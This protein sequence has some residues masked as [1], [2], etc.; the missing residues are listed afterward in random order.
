[1]ME[2]DCSTDI[3]SMT[4]TLVD[5]CLQRVTEISYSQDDLS[6][7][8][9]IMNKLVASEPLLTKIHLKSQKRCLTDRKVAPGSDSVVCSILN[10]RYC[11]CL[12]NTNMGKQYEL[13]SDTYDLAITCYQ[14]ALIWYP[15]S[16]EAGHL[17]GLCLRSRA[18]TAEKLDFVQ[19]IWERAM[20]AA[21]QTLET[22]G[23]PGTRT[24]GGTALGTAPSSPFTLPQQKVWD[25]LLSSSSPFP[26]SEL[27]SALSKSFVDNSTIA[28]C[29][30]RAQ[31]AL[32]FREREAAK[33]LQDSLILFY[34][35]ENQLDNAYPLLLLKRYQ[36]KLSQQVLTHATEEGQ[37]KEAKE[38]E[39]RQ[40]QLLEPRADFPF[41][42]GYDSVLPEI[43]LQRLQHVFRPSA[44][45]WSEHQYDFYSNCSRKV[46]Y[47][48]YLYPFRDRSA[49]NVIEQVIDI[50]Y[51][52]VTAQLEASNSDSSIS[53]K[54]NG[55]QCLEALRSEATVAE[56]WVHSRPHTSGHQFHF[57]SDETALYG[58]EQ[59]QVPHTHSSSLL[60][61]LTHRYTAL[62]HSRTLF[63]CPPSYINKCLII[64]HT[65]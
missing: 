63:Y 60:C 53:R 20:A 19:Y 54:Q 38:E 14:R 61:C 9:E 24:A 44:P 50:V 16:I 13:Q 59:A 31:A 12:L 41:T 43:Y 49:S 34:C 55:E 17:L 7:S 11:L 48:S 35:Q 39:A 6:R 65:S 28:S 23:L 33:V 32:E 51:Q 18:V 47:F 26:S 46:G 64:V 27:E 40:V 10:A 56:W 21:T 5:A 58:G 45:F 37:S 42:F 36:W 30:G 3:A 57:D 2:L 62:T 25:I 1:M 29:V 4:P 22:A 52:T 15:H 8:E